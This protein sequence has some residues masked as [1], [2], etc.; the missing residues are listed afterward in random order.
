MRS[1]RLA[2]RSPLALLAL[3][4]ALAFAAACDRAPSASGLAEWTPTDHDP[5]GAAPGPGQKPAQ[6]AAPRDEAE[7]LADLTWG[8]QCAQCHGP[9]GRGDGPSGPMVKAPDLTRA[10]WQARVKDE[11]LAATIRAGRGQMPKFDL[12]DAVIGGLVKR[13][14]KS[15]AP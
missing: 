2:T 1:P 5:S 10:D 13:I 9:E 14:R 15:R 7:H 11:E 4:G 6:K 12:S 3:L 8:A